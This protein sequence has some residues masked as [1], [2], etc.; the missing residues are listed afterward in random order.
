MA[1]RK[2]T[3]KPFSKRTRRERT[4]P[5]FEKYAMPFFDVKNRKFWSVTPT[6]NWTVDCDTGRDFA[7]RFL[8]SCDGTV[9]WSAMFSQ[10][11]QG[12]IGAGARRWPD[13]EPR[14][15]GITV[16]FLSNIG[17]V[18]SIALAPHEK[19]KKKVVKIKQ[20]ASATTRMVAG[21]SWQEGQQ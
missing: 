6:G 11:V 10:I 15:N 2:S 8:S 16:G 3:R 21:F 12:M 5:F 9:R 13:G 17:S 18:L 1:K 4:Q 14:L 20:D 7:Y 19:T